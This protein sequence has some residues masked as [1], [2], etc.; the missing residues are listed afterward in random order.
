[1]SNKSGASSQ[2][3]SLPKG[4]GALKGIG[5][6]FSPDLHTGT[7]NFTVPIALPPGR[8]A[9]QPELNLVYST[10]NG[11]GPFGLGWNLSIPGVSRKTAKGIP[12]YNDT[13][14]VFIL[15]GAEDLVPVEV[16]GT[17]TTYRP[18]TEGLFARIEHHHDSGNSYWEVRSKDG[19]VSQYG[20]VQATQ[21]DPP[22]VAAPADR[23]KIFAWKLSKTR[24]PFGNRIVYDY[25]RD[26]AETAEHHWDQLY[27]KRIRYADYTD[28]NNNEQFLVSV[29]FNYEDR[30]DPF[31]DYR[32]GFE[33]RTT[34]RCST[35]EIRTHADEEIL[36]R[37]YHLIYLDQRDDVADLDQRL[38][39]N[40][41]SLL[42]Q[43]RVEG[44]DESQPAGAQV[45]ALPP[46][47]FGYTRFEPESRTGRDFFPLSGH[48]PTLSLGNP[49]LELADLFGN[50]L[51][52][53][54]EMNGSV[55]YWRNLGGGRFDLP[56]PMRDAP[57]GLTLAD[58]EVQLVDAN[59]DGRIDLLASSNGLSGY[60]PLQFNGE[61]DRR[62]FQRYHAVPSF[63][64]QDPEVKLVDLDGDGVTDAIR[65]G[66]RLECFFNDSQEG[67]NGTRFV[68]RQSL[69]V[70]PNINFSDPR[71][72]WGDMSGDG[73]Q[74]IVL[75]YDGN[76]EYWPNLGY[77]NWGRRI[78][79]RHSPRFPYGYDP[80]R[81]LVGDVDGDGLADLVYVD[82]GKVLLWINQSGNRWSEP[83]EIDGT[84]PLVDVDAVRLV[85]LLGT[86]IAGVLWSKDV[87]T[88]SPENY[89]F[90][91]LTGGVKPYVLNEMDNYMG[92]VTRVKYEP[93]TTFYLADAQR[94]ET[95]WQT[96]LP[97]PVQVVT[98]V[99]VIDQ[100]S[101][102]KLTT[103]YSYHHGYWDGAEREFR[104]FGRVEQRDTEAF[105]TYHATGLHEGE[106]GFMPV[107]TVHFSPPTLTKTWFHQGPIGNE[108]GEWAEPDYNPEFWPD[109][110][111]VLIRPP[112]LATFL[113]GLPRRVKRDALRTL[114]GSVLRTELYALD[115]TE[116]QNR[117]YTV[118]ESL[119]GVREE[120]PPDT[121]EADR[122]H[123]FFPHILAQRTTQWERGDD[124]M[125]QCSFTTDYDAFGQPRQ[126]T[127]VALPRRAARR[128]EVD[129]TR[130]LATHTG[131]VYAD[132]DP[133]LYL[134]DRVA[135][136][137]T[138]ELVQPP[139]V[140]ETEP[141][142]LT[143]VLA[144]QA[145]AAQAIHRN[146]RVMLDAWVPGEAL[147]AAVHLISHTVNHYDGTS[148]QPF[149]GRPAGE[150]GPYGALTRTESLAFT[151][152]EL[153]AAY[154]AQRPVYLDGAAALPPNAPPNFGSNLGYRREQN[155][156]N[157]YHDGYYFDTQRQKFDF[158]DPASP[159]RRGLV[160][161]LQDALGHESTIRPDDTWLLPDEVTD[162][163][164]LTISASYDYRV[165]Q[166]SEVTD[167]NGNRT[168][169]TF[170]PL[171]LLATTA[172]RGKLD[173][174]EGDQNRAS[175]EMIYDFLA[176]ANSPPG[177]RQ[178]VYVR[179]R[180]YVHH[181][182]EIEV[183][184]D[185]T[186]EVVE[187][188]DGFGRLLQTRTQA[189]DVQFGDPVFGDGAV[190]ADQGDT[191][192]TSA[193]V[194]GRQQTRD[195]PPNVVVSGWQTYDNKGRVVEKYEP[196]FDQG[197]D[198]NAPADAQLGQKATMFYDPR[199][200][201]IRTVNPDGSEQRVIY[202]V[203][204]DLTEPERFTPTP[205]ETY[206]YDANDNA[207]RTHPECEVTKEYDHH[208]NTPASIGIDA[209]GRTI[210]TVERNRNPRPPPLASNP[211]PE[212]PPI[213]EYITCSTYDITG[214]LLTITDALGRE[215][216]RHAYDLIQRPLRVDSI[217]AGTR[218][219]VMDALGNP[220]EQRDSK[221]AVLLHIYDIL[222]RPV[223]LWASD[224]AGQKLTLCERIEY[225]DG[226]DP[227][228]PPAEREAHRAAN[229]L[230]KPYQHYD[231]AGRLTF[232][233]YDF[234]GNLLE[235]TRQVI[236]DAPILSVFANAA[237]NNWQVES[238][239]ADWQ[240]PGGTSLPDHAES[241]L[242][243]TGYRT[244]LTYDALNR[245]KTMR[246]PQDVVEERKLLQPSY[247][248]AGALE[249]VDLDGQTYV[250][251]IAY[252]A[253]GQR[254]LIAYGN[255]VM[256]R[257]TYDPETFRLAR[258]RTER[259][260][261]PDELTYQPD[262]APLQD[263][264]YQDFAYNYDLTGNILTI[265][266]RMPGSGVAPRPDEL[267]RAFEYDAIYRLLSATGRE[268][269]IN[270]S[271][272]PWNERPKSQ[273][274]T[275]TQHYTER[276]CY[277]D[278]GN[279]T[280]MCHTAQAPGNPG[281]FTRNFALQS[282][283]NQ[284]INMTIAN[285]PNSPFVY[286]YD[287]NGNLISETTSRHFE[288][289][290]SDQLRVF[291]NQ[292]VG[293]EP[294]RHAHYLYDANGQRLKK[295]VRTGTNNYDVTVYID[296][297]F[298][299]HRR[300]RPG[301]SQQNNT[302]HIMD[303]QSR[304]ALVRVGNH[305]PNDGAPEVQVQFHLGDHLGS[306]K[307]VI[308]GVNAGV[309]SFINREEYTP[310]GETSF[311]SFARK[312]YRFIGK[313]RDE[314]SG[315][316]YHGARY[317]TPWLARWVSCDPAGTVD[318]PNLYKPFLNNPIRYSDPTGQQSA[319][320]EDSDQV[321]NI[322]SKDLA[323]DQIVD[324]GVKKEEISFEQ[325]E[326]ISVKG[327]GG[328]L[329]LV[330]TLQVARREAKLGGAD[331][332]TLIEYDAELAA[333]ERGI[334]GEFW[335]PLL[336]KLGLTAVIGG[337]L[338]WASAASG[339]GFW[340][341]TRWFFTGS[342]KW[343]GF[344]SSAANMVAQAQ[345][346]GA[347]MSTY[348]LSSIFFDYFSG[349]IFSNV[350]NTATTVWKARIFSSAAKSLQ[351]WNNWVKQQS[352]INAVGFAVA[353]AR[354]FV[355]NTST[356]SNVKAGVAQT[357]FQMT[358]RA[359]LQ[360]ILFS[361]WGKRVF[362]KAF[363]DPRIIAATQLFSLSAKWIFQQV[364]EAVPQT[365]DTSN[366]K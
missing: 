12:R 120:S 89:F 247:N 44:V 155:S 366:K 281:G 208:W 162:P 9:F 325:E 315:L 357:G 205:W 257:Y 269:A 322:S 37:R 47:E 54:L 70:F 23:D 274:I 14:D 292:T 149:I 341:T 226:G 132:P 295:L 139:D 58:P 136:V 335:T 317:Y 364:F 154:G 25:E 105:E 147:P 11:N 294:T 22:V 16:S 314:E 264:A 148:E 265:H 209:L 26:A 224:G 215:A 339:G 87:G 365:S 55:R 153:D 137:R 30:P 192:G 293:A 334:S 53:I 207:G 38:P 188:S 18:R 355:S 97:F 98:C 71:V 67:W 277:D 309:N 195:D 218:L 178:P 196:F 170:T 109:D 124:P 303:D 152:V 344:T 122:L 272:F 166:P 340:A 69:D 327:R 5:E 190:P 199:G 310:Y 52:D 337:G 186:I 288:W 318:G 163:A 252:N 338:G 217:D 173:H 271:D 239:R 216:F 113:N 36:V 241:L 91:D 360:T 260:L 354:G 4:G 194:I 359:V 130:I 48:L 45:Q 297:I 362:P 59:G 231:E 193:N 24:D 75:V 307:T 108:F 266:D 233:S 17:V 96:P 348:N 66:T 276:Y 289:D 184:L 167:P 133:G 169:Y 107:D 159:Q 49:G 320:N 214:N 240:P 3:I 81:I 72:K 280:R 263:F 104:G 347:D 204:I 336:K 140:D 312:R 270:T 7:G 121:G 299:H 90:L 145:N 161:G 112:P 291:R 119:Y 127:A 41:V 135:Q 206:T 189:E 19:L 74:D 258:L 220:I 185:E 329:N 86:G 10:G 268:H 331:V 219:T 93:S 304:I 352:V 60:F 254:L 31:S 287:D 296:G 144:E 313:E 126:Q 244:S 349:A 261:K 40:G 138:F 131:T 13:G 83:L 302:L 248:R 245:I 92:A 57:A 76:V 95:R 15:S 235:K 222:N 79:M 238:Y 117:P 250:E 253:K 85:D 363:D 56:R 51:P 201:M 20:T 358:K 279:M 319:D 200:Q 6:T 227:N 62:S 333:A 351:T 146:F 234:K 286:D 46:L 61:W 283:N 116:R 35:I 177:A 262:S 343:Y 78:S 255:N 267:D 168:A 134:H 103:E 33:I 63:N 203:P 125:A 2:V 197:W 243:V 88:P 42:S 290:H 39:I 27:L 158:H 82:H 21:A 34:K 174:N 65:S 256:T 232:E 332:E 306:S 28:A 308:G 157:G 353:W 300:I 151:D 68:E 212:L 110:P 80:R 171:G 330:S 242:D 102:G 73:L 179:T 180:R 43:V 301:D 29:T 213:E 94:A 223:Q 278:V 275:R 361:N 50:G 225:G 176:F 346:H 210:K 1:M 328:Y 118:T 99:E 129:E 246:Y 237:A 282:D 128:G 305:F 326:G 77:G 142:E 202:G 100:L 221:G 172:V 64:L 236:G 106:F 191:L 156:A 175:V 101:G 211:N 356:E 324:G 8:N 298:E 321:D 249:S 181:D 259:H 123:I 350:A 316:Y 160:I 141:N 251:H 198:F 84:P 323:V 230:G 342:R 273:D 285:N 284:L 32:A 183:P 228:Q 311:G 187:Y 165:L 115:G 229:R 345:S 164:G 143:R 114:R 182:T 111:Q 150:V